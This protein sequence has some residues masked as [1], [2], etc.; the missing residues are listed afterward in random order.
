MTAQPKIRTFTPEEMAATERSLRLH[1]LKDA[2]AAVPLPRLA[3]WADAAWH[4]NAFPHRDFVV[5]AVCRRLA[6]ARIVPP[7]EAAR[8]AEHHAGHYMDLLPEELAL[9]RARLGGIGPL[10]RV[11]KALAAV[12]P[13]TGNPPALAR[14]RRPPSNAALILAVEDLEL[15]L[16]AAGLELAAGSAAAL[17]LHML[18]VRQLTRAWLDTLG[19]GAAPWLWVWTDDPTGLVDQ[20]RADL[21]ARPDLPPEHVAAI[22]SAITTLLTTAGLPADTTGA[23]RREARRA[24]L[25]ISPT[26]STPRA[27]AIAT[28]SSSCSSRTWTAASTR[29]RVACACP[30]TCAA[31][32]ASPGC[33]SPTSGV[34]AGNCPPS[35]RCPASPR[36][37]PPSRRSPEPSRHP[38]R[39]P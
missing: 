32:T 16:A 1:E 25:Q 19:A 29:W 5:D 39:P 20:A 15:A 38:R 13:T 17:R 31:R 9:A 4:A 21:A 27:V 7:T 26:P 24:A 37:S 2:L 11:R 10:L 22:Q 8:W 18:G 28:T 6:V 23:A 33:G 30:A 12:A 35:R 34:C 3:A 36:P 14:I